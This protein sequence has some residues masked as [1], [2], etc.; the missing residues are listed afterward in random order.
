MSPGLQD[1]LQHNSNLSKCDHR[2]D[3][4]TDCSDISKQI[5]TRQILWA[6][7]GVSLPTETEGEDDCASPTLSS[8]VSVVRVPP[9]DTLGLAF[10]GN[11]CF[12]SRK[13][14]QIR[15]TNG[16][17]NVNCELHIE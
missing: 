2:L 5:I 3:S 10:T 13:R 6:G 16:N 15:K 1:V 12:S 11:F 7:V 4:L 14:Y 9:S 8:L 17:D